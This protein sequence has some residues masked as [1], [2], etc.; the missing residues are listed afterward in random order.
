MKPVSMLDALGHAVRGA[1]DELTEH[2]KPRDDTERAIVNALGECSWD[3]CVAAIQKY[4][5]QGPTPASRD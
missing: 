1:R 4:R 3:E 2:V 5:S